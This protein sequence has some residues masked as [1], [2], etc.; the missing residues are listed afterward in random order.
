MREGEFLTIDVMA[1]QTEEAK[2]PKKICE[3]IVTKEALLEALKHIKVK[4]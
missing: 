2:A 4:E 1:M 3:L